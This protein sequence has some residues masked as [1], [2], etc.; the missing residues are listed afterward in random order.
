[1]PVVVVCFFSFIIFFS[2]SSFHD[3]F[4]LIPWFLEILFVC[5]MY[6]KIWWLIPVCAILSHGVMKVIVCRRKIVD[7]RA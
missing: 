2:I 7:C 5:M 6:L 4:F 1:M 3:I